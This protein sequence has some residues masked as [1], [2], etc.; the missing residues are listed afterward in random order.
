LYFIR[1]IFLLH[2]CNEY[3]LGIT[4]LVGDK[5]AS[6]SSLLNPSDD[7]SA[8]SPSKGFKGIAALSGASLSTEEQWLEPGVRN[9]NQEYLVNLG[10]YV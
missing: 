8:L 4:G 9:L 1:S 2:I 7:A 3:F 6:L 5:D 10:F